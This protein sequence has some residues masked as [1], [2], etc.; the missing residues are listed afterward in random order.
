VARRQ[1]LKQLAQ[2]T[3]AVVD[4][5]TR[6]ISNVVDPAAD[7]D[8]A[9]KNYVNTYV[10]GEVASPTTLD[11]DRN[12]SA[13]SGDGSSTGL[14]IT[15]TPAHDSYVVVQVNGLS[16]SVG[17][18]TK[19]KECY[20]SGDSGATARNIA[21][22]VAG[23]VL[24][25]NGAIAGVELETSW[26]V[27]F[28]YVVASGTTTEALPTDTFV[29]TT[30]FSLVVSASVNHAYYYVDSTTGARVG[31]LPAI[32]SATRG[33]RF[34][35]KL[36][37]GANTLTINPTGADTIDGASSLVISTVK[38]SYTLRCPSTGTDW[39]LH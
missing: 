19:T 10:G 18:G 7:Q 29:S 2:V 9:T 13:T 11:K 24:Y 25:W 1:H 36:D 34:D 39:K 26:E 35:I 20:F 14:A 12:P 28:F 6:K 30:P 37:A 33:K 23:D 4:V 3:T 22:I 27:D 21:D 31:T 8:A 5:E 32:S 17:D 38:V 15:S 16:Y